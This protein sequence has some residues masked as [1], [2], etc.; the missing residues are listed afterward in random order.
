MPKLRIRDLVV[1]A[2]VHLIARLHK[3]QTTLVEEVVCAETNDQTH[4]SYFSY[5]Q[6]CSAISEVISEQSI[7]I[8]SKTPSVFLWC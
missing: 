1:K 5:F 3:A 6:P 7:I 8:C 2:V 4:E